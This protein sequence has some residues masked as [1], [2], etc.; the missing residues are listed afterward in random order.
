MIVART[1]ASA[2]RSCIQRCWQSR[3]GPTRCSCDAR[4]GP[5]KMTTVQSGRD[6]GFSGPRP[7]RR[8]EVAHESMHR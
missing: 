1:L 3:G 7:R 2:A 4:S 5:R 8:V 6:N